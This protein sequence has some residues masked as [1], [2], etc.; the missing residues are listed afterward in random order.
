MLGIKSICVSKL[1]AVECF[2][3]YSI[4][5]SLLS[6]ANKGGG[7]HFDWYL[8]YRKLSRK[9]E[10]MG[11][12]IIIWVKINHVLNSFVTGSNLLNQTLSF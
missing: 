10:V 11:I 12:T 6:K 2:A 3:L 4:F 5:A 1:G 8:I 7:G 9:R